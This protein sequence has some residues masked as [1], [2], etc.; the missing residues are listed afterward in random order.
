MI[1]T[2][3]RNDLHV[4]VPVVIKFVICERILIPRYGAREVTYGEKLKILQ[5]VPSVYKPYSRITDS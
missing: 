5:S 4:F 3:L 2:G 1:S